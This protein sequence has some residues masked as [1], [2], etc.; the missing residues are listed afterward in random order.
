MNDSPR[1]EVHEEYQTILEAIL[2]A[3]NEIPC[4]LAKAFR[5]IHQG[6]EIPMEDEDIDRLVDEARKSVGI[7]P[8]GE[9][10]KEA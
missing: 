1:L 10:E 6:L 2:A 9:K 3:L 7:E 5:L 8:K 4:N